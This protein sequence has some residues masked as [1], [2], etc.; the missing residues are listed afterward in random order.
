MDP[1]MLIEMIGYLGSV[2]VL[3]SMLMSSV[4]KLRLIN[5]I[6]SVIFA[7]YAFIIQSYPTAIMNVVL[8][9]VNIYNLIKLLKTTKEYDLVKV[10]AKDSF[11]NYFLEHYKKDIEIYFPNFKNDDFFDAA[12]II[13]CKADPAGILL[14]KQNGQEIEIAIE[15]TTP[16]YRDC[17]VGKYLYQKLD[18]QG[19]DKLIYKAAD[20]KHADYLIKMGF[21][22]ENGEYVKVL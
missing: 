3:I 10:E 11:V 19:I 16:M 13:C 6:G 2:L 21:A 9:G 18:E 15:Y 8:I 12:Y 1:A 22:E 14:G 20:E 7:A 17:S 4:I 5:T